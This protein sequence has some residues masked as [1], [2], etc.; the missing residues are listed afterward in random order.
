MM[1]NVGSDEETKKQTEIRLDTYPDLVKAVKNATDQGDWVT[2]LRMG[3]FYD[4]DF[5]GTVLSEWS[6]GT[7]GPGPR[8][9]QGI[10]LWEKYRSRGIK[11]GVCKQ[12]K[13]EV[14]KIIQ[15]RKRLRQ[16]EDATATTQPSLPV[17]VEERPGS[18]TVREVMKVPGKQKGKGPGPRKKVTRKRRRPISD[19][20]DE[21]LAQVDMKKR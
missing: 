21:E 18:L 6:D 8:I 11:L 1:V 16:L 5:A 7:R 14:Q 19:R 13:S 12:T 20:T 17:L 4:L 2:I 9:T 10:M 15:E 3:D